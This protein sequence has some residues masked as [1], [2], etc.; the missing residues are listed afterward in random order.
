MN[1]IRGE[2]LVTGEE[3]CVC[4]CVISASLARTRSLFVNMQFAG[5]VKLECVLSF[6]RCLTCGCESAF[7]AFFCQIRT[8]VLVSTL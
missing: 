7:S 3:V 1:K 2:I 5:K 4:V 6:E 8:F